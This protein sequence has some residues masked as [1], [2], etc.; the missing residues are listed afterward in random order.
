MKTIQD[1]PDY[2][3]ILGIA[4]GEMGQTKDALIH[5]EK[6]AELGDPTVDVFLKKYGN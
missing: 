6:A 4:L 3:K 2:Y 5:L 1:N